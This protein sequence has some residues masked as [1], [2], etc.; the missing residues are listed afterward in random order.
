MDDF[1]IASSQLSESITHKESSVFSKAGESCFRRLLLVALM[2]SAWIVGASGVVTLGLIPTTALASNNQC[3]WENGPGAPTYPSCREEDCIGKGGFAECKVPQVAQLAASLPFDSQYW[4]YGI[5]ITEFY[6]NQ[7][8]CWAWGG[9]YSANGACSV[10]TAS[11]SETDAQAAVNNWAHIQHPNANFSVT[12][13]NWAQSIVDINNHNGVSFQIGPVYRDGILVGNGKRVV[14]S[15]NTS[16]IYAAI[17]KGRST[18]CP[19][20]TTTRFNRKYSATECV[21]PTAPSCIEMANPISPANAEK[22]QREVDYRSHGAGG[23][24][25]I[26]YF[27]SSGYQLS[28]DEVNNTSRIGAYYSWRHNYQN[29]L[30]PITSTPGLMAVI[31]RSDCSRHFFD[32]DGNEILNTDGAA[33]HITYTANV[34]YQ[35]SRA[36]ADQE[37]YDTTG[38]LM[39]LTSRA[40]I[41]TTLTYNPAGNLSTV[42]DAFGHQLAFVYDNN[43][44]LL[45][46]VTPDATTIAYSYDS[47]GNLISVA[48]PDNSQK[49][50]HYEDVTNHYLLTGITD[51]SGRRFATY[52]YDST[53]KVV[54]EDHAGVDQYQISLSYS[55]GAPGSFS[56]DLNTTNT[57]VVD[58]SGNTRVLAF[59]PVKGVLR[60]ASSQGCPSCGLP[61]AATYDN[62]GN[63]ASTTDYNNNL[64][65]Y[66]YDLTRNLETSRTEAY[67]TPQ[68]RT[69]TT[70]WHASY[71]LPTLVTEPGRTTSYTYDAHGNQLIRTVTDTATS[72]ART[73]TYT[74]NNFG[75]VL[76][77]D[78]PRTDVNDVTTYTYY[79]C[80]AGGACGQLA[81]VTDAAGNQTSYLTYNA[82]GQP[83]TISD[84]NGVVTTLTYDARQRLTSHSIAGEVT[85]F[86]YWPTGLLKK[87]T[88]PDSSSLSYTYDD[89]HRLTAMTDGEGNRIAYTLDAAGNRTQENVYDPGNA[90]ARTRSRVFDILGRLTEDKGALNQTT[91]YSYDNSGNVLSITDAANRQTSYSY[92]PLNRLATV[93][94]P[95]MGVTQY[96]YDAHDN[97]T[98]VTDPH[99]LNTS[100]AYNGLSDQT[101]L[102]SPDTGGTQY[103]RDSAG[104]LTQATDARNKTATYSYDAVGRVTQVQYSDQTQTFQYD[105]GTNGKGHLTQMTDNSGSTHWTYDPVG[106]VQ[107]AQHI[108]GTL[109]RTTSYGYTNGQ[110]TNI[111]TPSG[112]SIHYSYANGKVSGITVNGAP[113]L[114]QVLYSP[115]GPTRGWTWGNNTLTVREYNSDGQLTT[116]DSAG[117]STYTYNPVGT[118]ATWSSDT[119]ANLGLLLGQTDVSVAATSNRIS[120]TNG[121]LTRTYNYD[122]AGNT[123][124]DGS[125]TFSYN[126]AG[127]MTTA[128]SASVSTS[129]SYNA[130]G[131][132]V[133][134]SSGSGRTYFVYDEVGHLIGEYDQAGNLIQEIVWLNDIPVATIRTDQ[135]GS[136]VGVFYVHTDHLNAPT[137]VTRP[138]DNAVIW[139]W[140]HDPY[141]NGMPNQ[142]PDGNG[143]QLT[144]NLRFPG[145]YYDSETGLLYN[146]NRYYDPSTGRYIES[147]P[148]G[149][150][151]GSFST[152][153]YANN[154][155]V[156]FTDPTG[157]AAFC[158]Q[159]MKLQEMMRKST[160]INKVIMARIPWMSG[161]P[162]RITFG[163]GGGIGGRLP[164]EPGPGIDWRVQFG[165][166]EKSQ[167][168]EI[169]VWTQYNLWL[170][171]CQETTYDECGKP[172]TKY[173]QEKEWLGS[174]YS[175][176]DKG[177]TWTEWNFVPTSATYTMPGPPF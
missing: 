150:Y 50:Y 5:G 52:T 141:G 15:D 3:Q 133:K 89:A 116:I 81:T 103:V 25:F 17:T 13:E 83:L 149:L 111:T 74:Y 153:S 92:D 156:S 148:I 131:Q 18:V 70:Q 16:T 14:Y 11:A 23:I 61:S 138:T 20:D 147:D 117:L 130:L 57:S 49:A 101:Q 9:V 93:T 159:L 31:Q 79:N 105:Q 162:E 106:R 108:I 67:G 169:I 84:A 104:N 34:G 86:E 98:A 56:T 27:N 22:R 136:G 38:R 170:K 112:Q 7:Y 41:T 123:I 91:G 1:L 107:S 175:T 40:G 32:S 94:D 45:Q 121:T 39:S 129:Y 125:R 152:Y 2:A 154:N 163:P 24:E 53:G 42:S 10:L 77:V 85:S 29:V 166:L 155:P 87:I 167:L 19:K 36:S 120:G 33:E 80:T 96:G 160:E 143:L 46:V 161:V 48:Y 6:L 66:A 63:P 177:N 172:S 151:G 12:T 82:A 78:G 102:T 71:R 142:D 127:R 109:N 58:P 157:L 146:W 139:R 60:L 134:K 65:T 135:G 54:S 132:R 174:G 137:K 110:L 43:S 68:A 26:R 47:V 158:K 51:E 90:L 37:F 119:S 176:R 8:A 44:K 115:F 73:W 124:S 128:T 100:Y 88:L 75:Q 35:V 97:L 171:Q 122:N 95:T 62:N 72:T 28:F 165:W 21:K 59:T 126:D 4:T 30:V 64:T 99:S 168:T 140:D 145:Q 69:I 114:N 55:G 118:I 164:G 113:L 173:Y 76:T 144:M